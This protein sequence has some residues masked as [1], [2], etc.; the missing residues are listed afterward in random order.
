MYPQMGAARTE[1]NAKLSSSSISVK[2]DSS[3][4]SKWLTS[5]S[6]SSS[7]EL[8]V[9]SI[10]SLR[11]SRVIQ[12]KVDQRLVKLEQQSNTQGNS[13]GAKLKSKRG[14]NV[15]VYVE[16][17]V[18]WPHEAILRGISRQ[19]ITYDQ[20]SL[21]QFVQGFS[22]NILDESDK[23]NREKMIQYL[24]DS[25]EDATDFSWASV[26]A[27]H[28]VLLCEMERGSLDWEQTDRI[29]RIRR[30]HAQKH[31]G[32]FRQNWAKNE[33]HRRPWYCKLYQTGACSHNRD[34]ESGGQNLEAHLCL[35]F[36]SGETGSP[37]R[38]RLQKHK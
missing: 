22:K 15:D 32:N 26:K 23:K 37:S 4:S 38:E 3:K 31:A 2:K 35:L 24:S 20:L 36:G 1:K 25:M 33:G 18:A 14:G 17:R 9:P 7:D 16:K 6:D 34:H 30:V 21:T 13:T 5:S 27:A 12:H 10:K 11:T 8:D 29:D 28:A 19:R